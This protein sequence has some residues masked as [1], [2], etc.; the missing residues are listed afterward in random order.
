MCRKHNKHAKARAAETGGS[1]L[2]QKAKAE[3]EESGRAAGFSW[4]VRVGLTEETSE[5]ACRRG[6]S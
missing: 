4:A 1:P 5:R 3:P 2:W 6:R